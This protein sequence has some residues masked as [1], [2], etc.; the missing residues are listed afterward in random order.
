MDLQQRIIKTLLLAIVFFYVILSI[1]I[2]YFYLKLNS[3]GTNYFVA[4]FLYILIQINTKIL[5]FNSVMIFIVE[6]I[7]NNNMVEI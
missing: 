7:A 4:G 6:I 3:K 1:M 5:Y 2:H